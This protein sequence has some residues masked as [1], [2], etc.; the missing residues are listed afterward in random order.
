MEEILYKKNTGEFF[1]YG[2]GG[3]QTCYAECHGD[4]L[5]CGETI[6]P[7]YSKEA[8]EWVRKKLKT[9]TYLRIFGEKL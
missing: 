3:A 6:K 7:I 1:L 4:Q 2:K 8:K 5:T 9:E